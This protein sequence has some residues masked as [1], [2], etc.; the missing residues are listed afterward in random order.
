MD[1]DKVKKALECFKN[2]DWDGAI[3]LFTSL[4][5]TDTPFDI[6]YST[7]SFGFLYCFKII[8]SLK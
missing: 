3:N 5:E 4:L 6:K 8:T 2:K 7:N 1:N